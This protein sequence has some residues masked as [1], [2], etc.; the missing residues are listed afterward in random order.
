[1]RLSRVHSYPVRIAAVALVALSLTACGSDE[2]SD[3]PSATPSE[4]SSPTAPTDPPTS[5]TNK[6]DGSPS[7]GPTEPPAGEPSPDPTLPP[8]SELDTLGPSRT[9]SGVATEGVEAGCVVLQSGGK[10]YLLLGLH[11]SLVGSRVTV[12]GSVQTD[13]MSTCQQGIGF[14]VTK[15][16]KSSAADDPK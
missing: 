10:T 16:L 12:Q 1:M 7:T 13:M 3:E 5:P 9:L 14:K 8:P 15:V 4:E 6:P 2:P 11:P